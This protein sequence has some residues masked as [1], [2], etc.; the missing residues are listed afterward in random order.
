MGV[1]EVLLLELELLELE[2]DEVT[3]VLD[4]VGLAVV[5]EVD[6]VADDVVD[7]EVVEAEPDGNAAQVLERSPAFLKLSLAVPAVTSNFAV[8][9]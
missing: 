1:V 7:D 5:T 3:E 9:S 4:E 2:A 6:E 8:F